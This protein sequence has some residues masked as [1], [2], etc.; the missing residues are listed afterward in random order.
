MNFN[1][2]KISDAA[3][4]P[5]DVVIGHY[6]DEAKTPVGFKVVGSGSAQYI[7]AEREIQILNIK[8]AALRK[9]GLDLTTDAGAAVIADGADIRRF[10]TL[11]HCVVGWFG[12][13]EGFDDTPKVFTTEAMVSLLKT[14]VNWRNQILLA[15]E[16][17]AN[18]TQG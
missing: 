1:F 18:F 6:D 8:E 10:V 14:R 12:F 2:D 5:F 9:D 4:Q 17:E 11:R 15:I 3:S 7:A 16:D 13:T